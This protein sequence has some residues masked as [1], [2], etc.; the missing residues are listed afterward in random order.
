MPKTIKQCACCA[1]RDI[2]TNT[3]R[4]QPRYVCLSCGYEGFA[5]TEHESEEVQAIIKEILF[6]P[7]STFTGLFYAHPK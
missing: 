3:S 1:S 7:H 4:G 6:Q 2:Q 5:R